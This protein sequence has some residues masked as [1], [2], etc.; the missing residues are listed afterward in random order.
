MASVCKFGRSGYEFRSDGVRVYSTPVDRVAFNP[1]I[2]PVHQ[3][4]DSKFNLKSPQLLISDRF[5]RLAYS[6]QQ[7]REVCESNECLKFRLFRSREKQKS[8]T[9]ESGLL[10]FLFLMFWCIGLKVCNTFSLVIR[11]FLA[12]IYLSL[13][14][15][16]SPD[17][18]RGVMGDHRKIL[19]DNDK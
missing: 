6:S 19:H 7:L 1:S 9:V 12:I 16:F 17:E 10:V 11:T 15:L 4:V 5:L 14:Q 13:Y 2:S 8:V 18:I 3:S